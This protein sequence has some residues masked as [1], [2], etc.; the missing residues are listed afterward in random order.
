MKADKAYIEQAAKLLKIN[1]APEYLP[2]VVDNFIKMEAIA[3]LVMEF[4]LPEDIEVAS[5]FKP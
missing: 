5:T 2:G 3:S 4:D 1:I